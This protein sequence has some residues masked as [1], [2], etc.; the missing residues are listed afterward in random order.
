MIRVTRDPFGG[1]K[2]K[3]LPE[4][5]EILSLHTSFVFYRYINFEWTISVLRPPSWKLWV[6]VQV[7]TCRRRGILWRPHYRLHNFFLFVMVLCRLSV[8]LSHLSI[9]SMPI[10]TDNDTMTA[11]VTDPLAPDLFAVQSSLWQHLQQQQQQYSAG[12]SSSTH[13][14]QADTALWSQ[15]AT[16]PALAW[17]S[18]QLCHALQVRRTWRCHIADKPMTIFTLAVAVVVFVSTLGLMSG[19]TGLHLS[20]AHTH[21]AAH[22]NAQL[23]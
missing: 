7:T 2:V 21:I 5:G 22:C 16:C 14:V 15:S 19:K 18:L 1:R 10:Q 17:R 8:S 23:M 4:D 11:I 6:A 9:T 3:H 20:C 13:W 12:S